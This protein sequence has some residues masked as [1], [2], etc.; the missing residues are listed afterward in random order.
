MQTVRG[1]FITMA[2]DVEVNTVLILVLVGVSQR[3]NPKPEPESEPES[4]P[5]TTAAASPVATKAKLDTALIDEDTIVLD[6]SFNSRDEAISSLV[7]MSGTRFSD[8]DAVIE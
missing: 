5:E 8:P 1:L 2:T 4:T 7:D 6:A 3:R